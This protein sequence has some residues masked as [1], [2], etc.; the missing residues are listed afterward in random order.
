MAQDQKYHEASSA[1]VDDRIMPSDVSQERADA[2]LQRNN[3]YAG[4][5]EGVLTDISSGTNDLR[6]ISMRGKSTLQQTILA[7]CYAIG[8][9]SPERVLE[10]TKDGFERKAHM[11]EGM[12]EQYQEK[13]K[14]IDDDITSEK[15]W[16]YDADKILQEKEGRQKA[17]EKEL[18]Y[19]AGEVET[20]RNAYSDTDDKEG[21]EALIEMVRGY[22]ASRSAKEKEIEDLDE[23]ITNASDSF[24][25]HFEDLQELQADRNEVV[26][27]LQATSQLQRGY[28]R[29]ART[30]GKV[31]EKSIAGKIDDCRLL[32]ALAQDLQSVRNDEKELRDINRKRKDAVSRIP[33]AI[34]SQQIEE[35]NKIEL[36]TAKT[37]RESE[38]GVKL[39]RER[40]AKMF[41]I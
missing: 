11:L 35:S 1:I 22:E 6:E 4:S 40:R 7:A 27:M 12:K 26:Q 15:S 24:N 28:R 17:L 38:A 37:K 25:E 14:T 9:N 33:Q 39:A 20:C 36:D 31:L 30:Y 18:A 16:V 2:I 13:K 32:G 21:R 41:S 5:I 19:E 23:E 34:R 8:I 3:N 10:K 29:V